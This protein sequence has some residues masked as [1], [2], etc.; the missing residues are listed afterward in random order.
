MFPKKYVF[1]QLLQWQKKISWLFATIL[2][3]VI[4]TQTVI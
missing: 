4:T 2:K 1:S 3:P